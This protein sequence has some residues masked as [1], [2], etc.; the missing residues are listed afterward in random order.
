ME[1]HES[2]LR[3][4]PLAL[5]IRERYS[6]SYLSIYTLPAFFVFFYINNVYPPVRYDAPM[7]QRSQGLEGGQTLPVYL[8]GSVLT[9]FNYLQ[10]SDLMISEAC[11]PV[12]TPGPNAFLRM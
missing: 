4:R 2:Q 12:L 5:S 7:V 8:H 3:L 9:D 1:D 10:F 11:C 6:L